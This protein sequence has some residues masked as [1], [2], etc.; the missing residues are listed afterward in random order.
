MPLS[1]SV[2]AKELLL[3]FLLCEG[4]PVPSLRRSPDSQYYAHVD[5]TV[6]GVKKCKKNRSALEWAP[7]SL[8]LLPPSNSAE[9][10]TGSGR[11]PGRLPF[12]QGS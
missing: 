10:G 12:I 7:K 2:C 4:I 9:R 11:V 8:G 1:F 5:I 3:D 6:E